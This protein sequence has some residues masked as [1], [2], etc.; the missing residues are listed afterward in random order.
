MLGMQEATYHGV[1][2]LALPFGNDQRGNIVKPKSDGHAVRLDWDTLDDDSLFSAIN[3]LVYDPKYACI[4]K[5]FFTERII[6]R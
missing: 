3:Y 4:F 5:S 6:F 2:I 1:P